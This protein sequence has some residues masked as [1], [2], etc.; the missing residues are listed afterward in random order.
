MTKHEQAG[1][2]TEPMTYH[3]VSAHRNRLPAHNWFMVLVA[4]TASPSSSR[5]D[6]CVVPKWSEE[7]AFA[8]E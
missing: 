6:T 1:A 7:E 5:T 2:G 8:V 3:V 4:E